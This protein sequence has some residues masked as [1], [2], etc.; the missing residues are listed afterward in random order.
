MVRGETA[1]YRAVGE[2]FSTPQFVGQPP[3]LTPVSIICFDDGQGDA[4]TRTAPEIYVDE[5]QLSLEHARTLRDLIDRA[6]RAV[7]DGQA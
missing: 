2:T 7:E 4:V 5:L 6:L 3:A 1:H